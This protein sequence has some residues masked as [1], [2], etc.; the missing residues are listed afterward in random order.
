MLFNWSLLDVVSVSFWIM[1]VVRRWL[2]VNLSYLLL[3]VW[4]NLVTA[5]LFYFSHVFEVVCLFTHRIRMDCSLGAEGPAV[6]QL[7]KWDPSQFQLNLSEFREAFISPTKELL[8]LLSYQCE[9]LLLP[10]VTGEYSC[11]IIIFFNGVLNALD[12]QDLS[13]CFWWMI[14]CACMALPPL[15][16]HLSGTQDLI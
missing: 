14:T 11:L 1:Y 12:C 5:I 4:M 8:L 3:N 2:V 13:M 10:L 16:F 15:S 6:L 7:R 9:A